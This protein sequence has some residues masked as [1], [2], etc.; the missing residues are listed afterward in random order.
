MLRIRRG[1]NCRKPQ[2][3]C[4]T[5]QVFTTKS[6]PSQRRPTGTLIPGRQRLFDHPRTV[7]VQQVSLMHE[8]CCYVGHE[9][10][11]FGATSISFLDAGARLETRAKE[12]LAVRI[13][14]AASMGS[15]LRNP[16]EICCAS[17]PHAEPAAEAPAKLHEAGP[18]C[19]E[20]MWGYRALTA[21]MRR[22]TPG[23]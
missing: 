10:F 9:L 21:L 14:I 23:P 15:P 13:G 1:L 4:A 2:D 22:S 19:P 20:S 6:F 5:C 8:P 16:L 12:P 17:L 7:I 18:N 3:S 11:V